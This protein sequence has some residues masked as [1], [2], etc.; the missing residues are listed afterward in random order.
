VKSKGLKVNVL[1]KD[2]REIHGQYDVIASV[3]M[4][5][6]V[7][8]KNHRKFMK[9]VFSLL[10]PDGLFLLHTIGKN[11]STTSGDPWITKYIFPN[12]VIPSAKQIA[13][14]SEKLFVIKDWHA[15]PDTYY[16]KTLQ[17]WRDNVKKNK[18]Y[19]LSIG[20]DERFFRM[21]EFYLASSQASF[22][23][24]HNHLWQIVFAKPKHHIGYESVR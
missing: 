24:G 1:Y 23:T 4:F 21:W 10:K 11:R 16:A 17:A 18:K 3:G 12:S 13:K 7:G 6:H 5:E 14:A 15:F 9:K 8:P 19:L 20:Y 2:Y 22:A